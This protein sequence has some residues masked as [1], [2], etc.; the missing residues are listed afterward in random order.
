MVFKNFSL[1]LIVQNYVN[2][3]NKMTGEH[4]IRLNS[5]SDSTC[6]FIIFVKGLNSCQSIDLILELIKK[7]PFIKILNLDFNY[8]DYLQNQ[9]DQIYKEKI[10]K[11]LLF[12]NKRYWHFD[13]PNLDNNLIEQNKKSILSN[14]LKNSI[15]DLVTFIKTVKESNPKEII[16]NNTLLL[17]IL[18][19]F[20]KDESITIDT[21]FLNEKNILKINSKSFIE[22]NYKNITMTI[23]VIKY[24]LYL[25][26]K[27]LKMN[28]YMIQL[29]QLDNEYLINF[30]KLFPF[31]WLH[32]N[33]QTNRLISKNWVFNCQ[34]LSLQQ[35]WESLLLEH[36]NN[37]TLPYSTK[38]LKINIF[39]GAKNKRLLSNKI[40][41]TLNFGI[42]GEKIEH[43]SH[44]PLNKVITKHWKH[45]IYELL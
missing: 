20:P 45:S 40:I 21:Q 2:I 16:K 10:I 32:K 15:L 38:F 44:N 8:N 17:F 4:L 37:K 27:I 7:R 25:N 36:V 24:F 19:N 29:S 41:N 5:S 3:V 13:L 43:S 9:N 26:N 12:L 1:N 23:E 18:V 11:V 35:F 30:K 31:I 34:A 42:N 39:T 28:L 14:Y 6:Q 22:S 33:F